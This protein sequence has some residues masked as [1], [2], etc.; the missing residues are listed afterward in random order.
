M[1]RSSFSRRVEPPP[2]EWLNA[3]PA[4]RAK[5]PAERFA[6]FRSTL[7]NSFTT[8]WSSF[9]NSKLPAC[10]KATVVMEE[11]IASVYKVVNLVNH[12]QK[13][14][15]ALKSGIGPVASRKSRAPSAANPVA[16]MSLGKGIGFVQPGSWALSNV[17]KY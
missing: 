3:T 6:C 9:D 1:A 7:L 11:G 10:F 16:L 17:P 13:P 15:G 5:E 4:S 14:D 2:K 8:A 12:P